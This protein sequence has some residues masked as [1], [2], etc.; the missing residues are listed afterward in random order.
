MYFL[1]LNPNVLSRIHGSMLGTD[2]TITI[3]IH[4]LN[5]FRLLTQSEWARNPQAQDTNYVDLS[6]IKWRKGYGQDEDSVEVLQKKGLR[7]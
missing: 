4:M 6:D 1:N 7:E 5:Q 3:S 2:A